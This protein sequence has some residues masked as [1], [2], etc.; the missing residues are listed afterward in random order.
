MNNKPEDGWG[1]GNIHGCDCQELRGRHIGHC[2]GDKE[3]GP[4]EDKLN[5]L[6][7]VPLSEDSRTNFFS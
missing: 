6:N 5:G 1:K 4:W 2:D 3:G 7:N